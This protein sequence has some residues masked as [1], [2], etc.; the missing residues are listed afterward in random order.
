MQTELALAFEQLSYKLHKLKELLPNSSSTELMQK[1][2]IFNHQKKLISMMHIMSYWMHVANL[3][4]FSF[5]F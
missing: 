4:N 1:S 2:F 5:Y 3:S